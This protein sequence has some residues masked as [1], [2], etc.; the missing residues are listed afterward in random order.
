MASSKEFGNH[1]FQ[2]FWGVIGQTVKDYC[3]MFFKMEAA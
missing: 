1:Y 3:E 2:R